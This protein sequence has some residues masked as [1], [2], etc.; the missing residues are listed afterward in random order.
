MKKLFFI[1]VVFIILIVGY[2]LGSFL[3]IT[4]FF[5]S[6]VTSIKGNAKLEVKLM[7]DSNTPISNVEVDVGQQAGPPPKNG[8][9]T[10]DA[11]GIATFYIQPGNYVIYFNLNN[12][13]ANLQM[14]SYKQIS[15][16]GNQD[17]SQTI[18]VKTK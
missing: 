8:V 15:V 10:T 11:N 16:A 4:G 1:I 18:V 13:P 9:S 5:S 2:L 17:N 3:P 12:F 6:S 7:T 14:P